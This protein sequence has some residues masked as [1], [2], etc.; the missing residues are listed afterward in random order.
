MT[1]LEETLKKSTLDPLAEEFTQMPQPQPTSTLPQAEDKLK[2]L[3]KKSTL[4]PL[5]KE[6]RFKLNPTAEPFIAW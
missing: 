6:F 5:A 3:V 2:E 1:Q 4:N